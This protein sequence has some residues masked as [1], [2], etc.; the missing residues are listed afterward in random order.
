MSGPLVERLQATATLLRARGGSAA[1]RSLLAQQQQQEILRDIA[2]MPMVSATQAAELVTALGAVPWDA[3]LG[4]PVMEAVMNK[5]AAAGNQR[6][7]MQDFRACPD[8][9]TEDQWEALL[10]SATDSDKLHMMLS[11][12]ATLGLRTPSEPTLQMLAVL[13]CCV[14]QGV[15]GTRDLSCDAKR[16]LL[17]HVKE[18][19]A[20]HKRRLQEPVT[21]VTTFS[22]SVAEYV[23][24]HPAMARVAYAG[25][26]AVHC[27][28]PTETLVSLLPQF[29]MRERGGLARQQSVQQLAL[30]AP[31]QPAQ[32]PAQQQYADFMNMLQPM[33]AAFVPALL[34]GAPAASA[35]DL[36]G[37]RVLGGKGAGGRGRASVATRVLALQQQQLQPQQQEA[38]GQQAGPAVEEEA[39]REEPAAGDKDDEAGETLPTEVPDAEQPGPRAKK[40]GETERRRHLG[41]R[42][43]GA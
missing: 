14:A 39:A 11:H 7:K 41:F 28:V 2:L 15:P 13:W 5:I 29:H 30:Q 6:R 1:S 36:P 31:Q 3:R 34:Q 42:G 19:W 32:Q 8:Y 21:W 12:V 35:G 38:L 22:R 26:G 27:K 17:G 25:G 18:E 9:F 10:G 16:G 24:E 23:V 40:K 43:R 4:G 37:L 20:R 33:L